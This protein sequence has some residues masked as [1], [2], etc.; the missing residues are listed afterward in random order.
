[1][2]RRAVRCLHIST[3]LETAGA[4]RMLEKLALRMDPARF[5]TEIVSLTRAGPVGERLERAGFRVHALGLRRGR[6][7]GPRVLRRLAGIARAM[8]PDV[9]QT[10]LYHADLAGFAVA[11]LVR[12][13]ALVWNLR[14]S[15]MRLSEGSLLTRLIV[16]ANARLSRRVDAIVVNSHR[17]K[18]V[19]AKMG[20]E[21]ARMRVIP[22]GFDTDAFRP[23]PDAGAALRDWLGW[24][25]SAAI[26]GIVAR[27]H[28]MKG[29]GVFFRAVAEAARLMPGLHVVAIGAGLED[30]NRALRAML[31]GGEWRSRLALLGERGDVGALMAGMDVL[32]SA[33]TYGE[34]CPNAVGEAMACGVP[35][36]VSDV[37][38]APAL[39]GQ[40][41]LVVPAGQIAPLSAAIAHVVRMNPAA[42]SGLG[43]AARARIIEHF[44]IAQITAQ[45]EA[46]YTEL[47]DTPRTRRG[48]A[49]RTARRSTSSAST[50]AAPVSKSHARGVMVISLD[51]EL[52]W[53]TL[54]RMWFRRRAG[55]LLAG[56]S[57][58]EELLALLARYGV[59]A[60]WAVTGHLC[61]DTCARTD[62]E[63]HQDL[64]HGRLPD[65]S[66]W[67]V[68]D[69]CTRWSAAPLWYA[70]DLVRRILACR[71]PQELGCHGFSH[72]EL[73][74]DGCAPEL[75]RDEFRAARD[76]AA[77]F[78]AE[79]RALV[80]PRDRIGHL[81]LAREAGFCVYRGPTRELFRDARLRW[82]GKL[83]HVL[84]DVLARTPEPVVAHEVLPGLWELPGSMMYQFMFGWR[85]LIP[86][87]ARVARA[88]RGIDAAIR[89][90]AVFHLWTHPCTLG[91]EQDR[92]LWGFERILEYA[93]RRRREGTL[94]ILTMSEAA[95]RF[96]QP[97][98]ESREV[99][100]AGAAG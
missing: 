10:W 1:M 83:R 60:T 39:V 12:G 86:V 24:P 27:W 26:V 38:D 50:G 82:A 66:D 75:A 93:D 20:Y 63:A 94:D 28:P 35:C 97:A 61:L 68:F 71:V 9:I 49:G 54:H 40:T 80:Y 100:A 98:A 81:A 11:R 32:C 95:R 74:E 64:E 5:E 55:A 6:P 46:L 87:R 47:A 58:S 34:G 7:A 36:I 76:A 43:E 25:E 37:G 91:V 8:E 14:C 89:E 19:H 16:A 41:G 13:P 96:G 70:P 85:R 90:G 42:R 29:H 72:V 3:D 2:S 53:G 62:G 57:A 22:N 78:G 84:Q 92:L 77:R 23:D 30:E 18:A 73:S 4:E 56:R 69:P 15:D 44:S 45:Y 33:S 99:V 67:Y 88:R 65:G 21:T 48:R 79:L 17:G 59:S 52:A 31:P 51:L